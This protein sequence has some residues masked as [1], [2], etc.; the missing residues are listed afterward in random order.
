[1]ADYVADALYTIS[2]RVCRDMGLTPRSAPLSIVALSLRLD[3]DEVGDTERWGRDFAQDDELPLLLYWSEGA[4]RF[5]GGR[6]ETLDDVIIMHDRTTTARLYPPTGRDERGG[7]TPLRVK[8]SWLPGSESAMA[9]ISIA[10]R[11]RR[12]FPSTWQAVDVAQTI[13]RITRMAKREGA[14]FSVARRPPP[15]F[16]FY[17]IRD[18]DLARVAADRIRKGLPV[19]QPLRVAVIGGD[20]RIDKVDWPPDLD[21]T[22]YT[23]A[24]PNVNRLLESVRAGKIDRIVALV[25]WM[26][27]TTWHS[28]RGGPAPVTAWPYGIPRLAKELHSLL[29][30][31][32]AVATKAKAQTPI[33]ARPWREI[34]LNTAEDYSGPISPHEIAELLGLSS[35][36]EPALREA[37]DYHAGRGLVENC[38]DGRY[39]Y[40]AARADTPAL[41]ATT[42]ESTEDELFDELEQSE[43]PKRLTPRHEVYYEVLKVIESDPEREWTAPQISTIIGGLKPRVYNPLQK[44]VADGKILMIPGAGAGSDHPA[45]FRLM[46]SEDQV[47]AEAEQIVARLDPVERAGVALARAKRAHKGAQAR[48]AELEAQIDA[49]R[50]AVTEAAEEVELALLALDEGLQ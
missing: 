25:R 48:L 24:Q 50:S 18:N 21:V 6:P 39:E 41:P 5:D 4:P 9:I 46:P 35:D 43:E 12:E 38:A 17:E 15:G 30:V 11:M 33:D 28:L 27:H 20:A 45:R 47:A 29:G 26:P 22:T 14:D 3:F 13:K 42:V 1:M 44:L 40:K 2:A 16:K 23:S 31:K 36:Y 10:L 49:A 8:G 37:L 7:I 34:V 32:P 19:Q